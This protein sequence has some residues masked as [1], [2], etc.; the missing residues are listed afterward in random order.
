MSGQVSR[1]SF[2]I[3]ITIT[4]FPLYLKEEHSYNIFSEPKQRDGKKQRIL[5]HT[6]LKNGMKIINQDKT[7]MLTEFKAM[8]AWC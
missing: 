1:G 6:L 2:N 8:V 7:Q 5:E 4:G 3:F